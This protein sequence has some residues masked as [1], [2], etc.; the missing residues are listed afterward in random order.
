MINSVNTA[1]TKGCKSKYRKNTLVS[2]QI[3]LVDYNWTRNNGLLCKR[4]D[5]YRGCF[6]STKEIIISCQ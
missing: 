6:I 4:S 2:K 5:K 3:K 1:N